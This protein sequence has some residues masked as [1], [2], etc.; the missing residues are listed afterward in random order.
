MV[1]SV[2]ISGKLILSGDNILNFFEEISSSFNTYN[3]NIE[4]WKNYIFKRILENSN[5]KKH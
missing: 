5:I 2:I 3:V 1:K 4:V